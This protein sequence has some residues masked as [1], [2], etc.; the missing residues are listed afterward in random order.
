MKLPNGY[1]SVYKLSGKRR[2]PWAARKTVGW[3]QTGERKVSPVYKFIGYFETKE[4]ALSALG[5]YNAD[6]YEL[7]EPEVPTLRQ[8]YECWKDEAFETLSPQQ[9]NAYRT[10]AK[11]IEPIMDIPV[12]DLRLTLLQRTLDASGKNAPSARV[13]KALYSKLFTYAV[14]HEYITPEKATIAKYVEVRAGNP[15]ANPHTPFTHAEID[16]LWKS[17][18]DEYHSSIMLVLIYT[19]LRISELLNLRKENVRLESRYIEV[20][21]SKTEAGVRVVPIA[22]KI[23][24][25]I[26]KL[27]DTDSPY[28]IKG[29]RAQRISGTNIYKEPYWQIVTHGLDHDPHDARHTCAS[30]LAEAGVDE[31][32]VRAILGHSS[33]EVTERVYTHIS[34][35]KKL[36]AINRI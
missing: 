5:K 32:I 14:K 19:G 16:Y 31:R 7:D 36:D 18:T 9:S 11:A 28:L 12:A 1:G 2:K 21:S 20:I 17:L 35:E 29:K 10:A 6:P 23:V 25:L 30:L 33:N 4:Q 26:E 34:L 15:N 13:I 22:E 24:P 27:A 8:V 3:K